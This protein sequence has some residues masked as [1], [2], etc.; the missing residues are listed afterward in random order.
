MTPKRVA[1]WRG[2]ADMDVDKR[3]EIAKK[4]APTCPAKAK[5]HRIGLAAAAGRKGGHAVAP[6]ARS[7][8]ANRD[9][10]SQAGRRRSGGENQWRS[11]HGN[12]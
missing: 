8:T 9:L 4:G 3:R 12:G 1:A 11:K 10:A 5:P 2:F 6:E 7:F